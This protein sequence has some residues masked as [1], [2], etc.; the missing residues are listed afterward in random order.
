M[1][2]DEH[3]VDP[4]DEGRH[5]PDPDQLWNES[6][7]ADFV[8]NDRSLAGYMRWGLYP[9]MGLSWWTTTVV[10]GDEPWLASVNYRLAVPDQGLSVDDGKWSVALEPSGDL[11]EFTVRADAPATRH[12]Q[13]WHA[14]AGDPGEAAHLGM[15]LTWT[16]DGAPYHYV[17]TTRYEVPCT[18]AGTITVD[19]ERVGVEGQG[20][21][22]HSWGVRDWWTTSWCW[23]SCRL[24]DGTRFHTVQ[25]RLPGMPVFFGYVQRPA[26]GLVAPIT[27]LSVDEELGD[28][29][30]PRRARIEF[31]PGP[32]TLEVEPA[33][34]GPL[35]L[36]A[37]D[38]RLSRFPRAHIRVATGDGRRGDGWIEFNQPQP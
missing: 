1:T 19:G 18:V 26:E 30:L 4:A 32:V 2:M 3:R 33:G 7:Y 12:A 8:A 17:L 25:V 37:P 31:E 22:D 35:L 10:R 28:H 21:R 16:T 27:A 13:P 9:N 29:G 15:D 36:T 20:Q 38:G 23:M 11:K 5:A 24:D 34:F 14:Y 6:W